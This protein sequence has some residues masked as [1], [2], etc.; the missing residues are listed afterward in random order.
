MKQRFIMFII[1]FLNIV[2]LMYAQRVNEQIVLQCAENYLTKI[3]TLFNESNVLYTLSKDEIKGNCHSIN[4]SEFDHPIA[5]V[6]ELEPKGFIVFSGS[7]ELFPIISYSLDS[8]FNYKQSSNNVLLDML[9]TDLTCQFLTLRNTLNAKQQKAVKKNL[10]A[11][12]NIQ[13]GI[14]RSSKDDIQYGPHLSS[15][16]GGVNCY[17]NDT[18]SVFVGN[19]YTPNH[20]SPGCVATSMSQILHYFE[21]PTTGVGFYS[22]YDSDGSTQG[23][24]S[25]NFG[26]TTYDWGNMLDEYYYMP[27]T[28]IE[29]SAMGTIA[30]HC[31]VSIDM[32]YENYGSTSNINRVDDALANYFRYTGHYETASWSSF[33]TRMEQNLSNGYPV[34][35][36]I[37]ATNGA[38]HAVACD[39]LQIVDSNNYYHL[40][41]GWWGT[42]NAWYML[43]NSFSACGY[44]L[45]SSAVFDI[46]PEPIMGDIIST[47]NEKT[48]TVTWS[49]SNKLNWDAFELLQQKDGGT[50]ITITSTINDTS[51]QVTVTEA[52]E[53]SY[54]VRAKSNGYFYLNS[55]SEEKSVLVKEDLI[56]LD[57]DEND[58]FFVNDNDDNDLD[59]SSNWTI[60]AWVKVDSHT[61]GEY[62]VILDRRTVF[63]MY[64]IDDVS[65][66]YAIR[67]VARD[68]N[69]NIIAS[70]RSDDSATDLN[71]DEWVHVAASR[72][73]DTTRLFL[74][75]N[76]VSYSTDSDF[77]LASSTNALNI[78]ARYWGGYS[79][80]I[81]GKIDEI[82]ISQIG[83]YSKDFTINREYVHTIDD[84]TRILLNL[85]EGTG[86]SLADSSKNFTG[87]SL[88]SSPNTANWGFESTNSKSA[89]VTTN[90]ESKTEN[91]DLVVFPNPLSSSKQL[92]VRL[93][94]SS[95]AYIEIYGLT[96]K[97]FYYNTL[98]LER[99]NNTGIDLSTL[100][101]GL[102]LYK[103]KTSFE[104]KTGKI[105]IQ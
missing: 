17:D 47:S 93:S 1:L 74:D 42:C 10:L 39:G 72:S 22:Y 28:N 96:G 79:R 26:N 55:Y 69:G 12:K 90:F 98:M 75:G 11:W 94:Y 76:E 15:I 31:G 58:S 7:K 82:R 3:N 36:A 78:G 102:Y 92:N 105:I 66:D 48:F 61:S 71:Y 9:I 41:M 59:I 97:L 104:I 5:Y 33:W 56:F 19:Y 65:A 100:P 95:E 73:G 27:S 89:S 6:V 40:N 35:L 80:Y 34:Q 64:L 91:S 87:I 63:S 20:Y 38:G 68:L 2:N 24:H 51:Y 67:F 4:H 13:K 50:W 30:Y 60:E 70:L 16:W 77:S 84:N 44:S 43:Q 103:I 37:Y 85:Q 18:N 81:D 45:V 54:K 62:A 57:F 53:Y 46:L 99:T 32:D 8:K 25:V 52:G 86:S 21:W 83:R 101:S 49:V 29:R 88:R 23:S 14:I